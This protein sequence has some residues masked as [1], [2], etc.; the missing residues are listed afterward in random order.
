MSQPIEGIFLQTKLAQETGETKTAGEN[1]R[2][3][4]TP[5]PTPNKITSDE[6]AQ[7]FHIDET[8]LTR[9]N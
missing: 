4:T 6:Q 2:H 9:S 8:S 1:G 3:F 5:P 7:K